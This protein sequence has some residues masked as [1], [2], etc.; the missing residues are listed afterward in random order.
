MLKK[1]DFGKE[2]STESLAGKEAKMRNKVLIETLITLEQSAGALKAAAESNMFRWEKHGYP[3]SNSCRIIVRTGDWGDVTLA[4][5][6]EFGTC[7]A[8]LN[9]ANAKTFG[10][11]YTHGAAAQEENMFRRTDCHFSMPKSQLNNGKYDKDMTNLLNAKDG[12]VS[13]DIKNPRICI[14]GPEDRDKDNLGYPWLEKSDW[15]LFYELRAAAMDLRP[16]GE[17]FDEK[18]TRKRVKAQLDTL[19]ENNIR[20]VVL[21]AFGCGAFL[22][23]AV[24]VAKIYHELLKDYTK[25]F[26]VVA[27]AIF[28]AGYGPNNY[29]PFANV[30]EKWPN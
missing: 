30:F 26:D 7:F 16:N 20:H 22:N 5:T 12:K 13:L 4:L 8:V 9:M 11:G 1:E 29:V 14:R 21:S 23:P 24:G 25:F 10:G 19:K 28:N 6:K 3:P 17:G 2:L 18:E 27:F 15:F